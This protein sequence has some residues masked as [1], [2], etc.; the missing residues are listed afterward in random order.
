[1]GSQDMIIEEGNEVKKDFVFV[2]LFV[3]KLSEIIAY[4]YADGRALKWREPMRQNR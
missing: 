1:M 2:C 4:W 3:C